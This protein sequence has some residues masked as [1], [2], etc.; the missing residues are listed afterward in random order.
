MKIVKKNVEKQYNPT[1]GCESFSCLPDAALHVL[2]QIKKYG[3][4]NYYTLRTD[5]PLPHR[6]NRGE[7]PQFLEGENWW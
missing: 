2:F 4:Q 5:A 3:D 6:K 1:K 7:R